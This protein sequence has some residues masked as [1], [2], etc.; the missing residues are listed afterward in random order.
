MSVKRVVGAQAAPAQV[1]TDAAAANPKSSAATE[2]AAAAETGVAA[3]VVTS[4]NDVSNERCEEV[5]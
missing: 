5:K 4:C 2:T 3:E 1:E